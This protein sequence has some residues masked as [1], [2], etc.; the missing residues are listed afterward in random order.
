MGEGRGLQAAAE[1]GAWRLRRFQQL[2]FTGP[3]ES[4]G[5]SSLLAL[6]RL[7]ASNA[8]CE[9]AGSSLGGDGQAQVP[10]F[11]STWIV[12]G[13]VP[14]SLLMIIVIVWAFMVPFN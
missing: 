7:S 13:R 10:G 14:W 9:A 3:S 12:T 5:F 1:V 4:T 8:I 2:K 11:V 6:V